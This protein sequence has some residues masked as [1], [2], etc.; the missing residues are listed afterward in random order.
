VAGKRVAEVVNPTIEDA[1][2]RENHSRQPFANGRLYDD[3]GPAYRI[4][5]EGYALYGATGCTFE[6]RETELRK[7]YEV[8]QPK[9]AWNEARAASRAAWQRIREQPPKGRKAA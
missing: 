6:D 7:R 5:Y 8:A 1:Y 2:W 9:L 3:Y 4:G